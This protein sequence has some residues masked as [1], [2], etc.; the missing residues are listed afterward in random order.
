MWRDLRLFLAG[1]ERYKLLFAVLSIL[2]PALIVIGFYVDSRVDPPGP[3]LIYVNSWPADRTDAE[4][5][6]QQKIDQAKR[7]AETAERQ[8]QF[9]ELEKRL[10]I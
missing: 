3:Q 2:M 5:T 7:D 6:A 9:K 4:I 1:Q 8:R 10:G